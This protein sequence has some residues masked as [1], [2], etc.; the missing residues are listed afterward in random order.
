MT[1]GKE[2]DTDCGGGECN[3]CPNGKKCLVDSDC[4][5]GTCNMSN[6]QCQ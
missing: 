6:Y 5:N 4:T 2:T 1:D 3:Q